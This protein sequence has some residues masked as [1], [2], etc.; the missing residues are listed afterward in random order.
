MMS[1][2][3][4]GDREEFASTNYWGEGDK[5]IIDTKALAFGLLT[6]LITNQV[7]PKIIDK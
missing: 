6:T 2:E 1:T 7:L 3:Q 4:K 5:I